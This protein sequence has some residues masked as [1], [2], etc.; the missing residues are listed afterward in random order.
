MHVYN[1]VV[2]KKPNIKN[3]KMAKE[4]KIDYLRQLL[5]KSPR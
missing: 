3:S 5:K 4:K 2:K 1:I